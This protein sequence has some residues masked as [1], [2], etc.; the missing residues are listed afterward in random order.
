MSLVSAV[1]AL[2]GGSATTPQTNQMPNQN[3]NAPQNN[4][5]QTQNPGGALPGTVAN[6]VTAPNGVVPVIG[7]PDPNAAP[8]SP[9]DQ[10]AEIWN[11]PVVKPGEEPTSMFANLDQKKVL[12]SARR[13]DFAGSI[14]P[15]LIARIEKGGPD[16][17]IALS[18]ALNFTGQNVY[19]NSAIA[20]TKIVE[21]AV[22]EAN[23]RFLAQL[24]SLVRKFSANENLRTENPILNN[25]AVQP[26]VGA[27]TEQLTRKNPNATGSEIQQQV[28]DYFASLGQVFAPKPVESAE[29]KR[30]AAN[31]TDWDKFLT[32]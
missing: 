31:A 6:G 19:A 12:E 14:D 10:F 32:S 11:T 24:P 4:P 30:A 2:F 13:V 20:T 8:V 29:S 9:L 1:Q 17:M 15:L 25:P 23:D 5:M 26:L 3:P 18:Q 28:V 7:N 22:T 21:K 16:A 27:L